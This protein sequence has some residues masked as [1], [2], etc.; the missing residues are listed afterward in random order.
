MPSEAHNTGG[1]AI[2]GMATIGIGVGAADGSAGGIAAAAFAAGVD[3]KGGTAQ[4]G[5][6]RRDV[7]LPQFVRPQ[8]S[9]PVEKPPSGPQRLHEIKLNAIVWLRASTTPPA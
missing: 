7:P 2:T 4:S 1:M 3:G 9:Q 5:R 8:L 6:S